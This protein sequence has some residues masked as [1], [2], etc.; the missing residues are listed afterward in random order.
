MGQSRH[1]ARRTLSRRSV[2]HAVTPLRAAVFLATAGIVLASTFTATGA[3]LSSLSNGGADGLKLTTAVHNHQIV[4]DPGPAA[5]VD[6]A[7]SAKYSNGKPASNAVVKLSNA[8]RTAVFHTKSDG[9]LTLVEP[10]N[11]GQNPDLS[12]NVSVDV[13]APNGARATRDQNLYS[14]DSHTVVCS[15]DGAPHSDISLLQAGLPGEASAIIDV[16]TAVVPWLSGLHTDATGYDFRI[17]G[18]RDVFALNVNITKHGKA[19][20]SDTTYGSKQLLKPPASAWDAIQTGCQAG[21]IA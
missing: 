17:P 10:I 1:K 7:V 13:T 3:T 8:K 15:F 21:A 19:W 14:V 2:L 20:K 6:L 16:L 9:T 5:Y 4:P 12:A 11:S 18:A